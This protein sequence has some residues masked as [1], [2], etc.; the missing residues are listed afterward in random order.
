M[1]IRRMMTKKYSIAQARNHLPA[2]VHDVEGGARVELTRRGQPVAV[3]LGIEDYQRL[4]E[5]RR[6]FWEAYEDFRREFDLVELG[7]DPDEI[8]AGT[9]DPSPGRGF[10]W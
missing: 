3:V 7:A 8:F 6:D 9:R 2:L 10:S 5:G 1:A 4:A